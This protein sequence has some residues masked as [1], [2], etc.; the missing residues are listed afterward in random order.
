[1]IEKIQDLML[2]QEVQ[3]VHICREANQIADAIINEAFNHE[4]KKQYHNHIQ[5]PLLVKKSIDYRQKIDSSPKDTHMSY[6][7][8]IILTRSVIFI[9]DHRH[10]TSNKKI[11]HF[12]EKEGGDC[13]HI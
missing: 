11:S 8:D 6:S 12:G 13:Q 4:H 10:V 7:G 3:V 2:N 9:V 5:L 1:M